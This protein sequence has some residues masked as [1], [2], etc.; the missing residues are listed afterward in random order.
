MGVFI[1]VGF[2]RLFANKRLNGRLQT[3]SRALIQFTPFATFLLSLL[4]TG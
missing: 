1:V 2:G 4:L 3:R